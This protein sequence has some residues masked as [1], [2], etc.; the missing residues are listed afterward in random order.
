MSIDEKTS[1]PTPAAARDGRPSMPRWLLGLGP[2]VL[3]AVLMA[4]FALLNGPGLAKLGEGAPP[5]E[6]VTI[7]D[8]RFLPGQIQITARNE[9]PDPVTIAQVNVS[10]Y[11]ASFTQTRN[12]MAPLEATTLTV[13]YHWVDGDPYE[14]ALVTSIGGKIPATVDAAALSPERGTSFFGLMTLL[15]IY[16]GVI[17]VALG[18][19]WMP[20]IRRSSASWIRLLLGVTVGLLAFLTVDATLEGMEL[21]A[22]S[23]AFGGPLVVFLG[24]FAAYLVLEATDAWMRGHQEPAPAGTPAVLPP[25]RLALL[26]AIGIGLHNLGEGL[27]IGSAYAVGSLALGATLIVGFAIHNTTEGL[28]IVTPLAK[29]P[30]RLGRLAVLGL[31]AGA[32]AIAGALIG[33]SVYQPTLAAFLLG[34][35]A[36]AV[37][38]VAFKILPLMKD[39]TGKILNPLGSAGIILGLATMFL[40]GLL[41]QA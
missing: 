13:N 34:L 40:T 19:L 30:A 16:V 6:E 17:P 9:G 26:I 35:G 7:E 12:T 22:G 36:G 37:A 38:Q 28:A 31:I 10:D 20:F 2:V 15:G 4:V 11:Y 3:I 8:V 29:E 39:S 25:R 14:I 5:K 33:A 18:M 41:V 27:A 24:A 1:T 21:V 32:P 23:G